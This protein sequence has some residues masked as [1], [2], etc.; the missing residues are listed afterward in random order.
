MLLVIESAAFEAPRLQGTPMSVRIYIAY[1]GPTMHDISEYT[2]NIEIGGE[3]RIKIERRRRN[4]H[5]KI[6]VFK[7][8]QY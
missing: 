6:D 8:M 5:S 3:G 2:C 7:N 1:T 4:I